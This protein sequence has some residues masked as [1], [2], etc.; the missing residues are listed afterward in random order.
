MHGTPRQVT[1]ITVFFLL[2]LALISPIAGVFVDRW[3][4][5]R[6]MIVS[7][8]SRGVLIL[9]LVFANVPEHVYAVLFAVSV[10]SSFFVP[11]QSVVVPQI[12]PPQGLLSANAAMQQ[13][14]QVVRIISPVV[15]GAIVGWFGSSI[16]Y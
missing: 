14:M 12:V 11:A 1:L 7:D 8:L 15:S 6:T 5:R 4:P 13:A 10:F 16:C 3:D 2:P 9:G